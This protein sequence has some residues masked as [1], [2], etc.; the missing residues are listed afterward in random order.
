M[1]ARS[2][3]VVPAIVALALVL[4]ALAGCGDDPSPGHLEGPLT[5]T[6]GGGLAGRVDQ[7]T[8]NPDGSATLTTRRGTTS[9]ELSASELAG[10][11]ADLRDFADAPAESRSDPPIP[12]A[13]GHTVE[14]GGRTVSAD[15]GAMPDELGGLMGGLGALVDAHGTP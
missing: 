6:R 4:A 5:Y 12:D 7:L 13:F 2:A 8:V 11:E 10:L 14:Y 15:D 1:R 9:F 3:G